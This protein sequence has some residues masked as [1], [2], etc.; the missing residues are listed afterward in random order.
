[1]CKW[2][3]IEILPFENR[4]YEWIT[5]KEIDQLLDMKS[6]SHMKESRTT[7]RR[8]KIY[9]ELHKDKQRGYVCPHGALHK[10]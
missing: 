8:F 7:A 2:I 5:E 10:S 6:C 4:I 1:M 3:Y 9:K